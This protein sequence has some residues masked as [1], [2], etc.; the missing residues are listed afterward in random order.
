MSSA[1]TQSLRAIALV[2]SLKK[3]PAPSSSELLAG[4]LLDELRSAGVEGE[5]VRCVD[6]TLL[7]GVEAD[8]G[9]GDEWPGLLDK[10]KAADIVIVSTPTWV[11]HMSSV[12]QRVLER[13]DAELS[14]TDDDG[15]PRMVG[16]VALAAVVGNE[17]GAHKIV[18]DLFQ[19]LNDIGFSIAAQGCTYW[20]GEAMQGTD[21]TDLDDVPDAVASATGNAVRNAVHLASVLRENTYPAYE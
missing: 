4:Q 18:A 17:D 19:A 12:A 14:D 5:K 3:S 21:Y 7:P 15:R 2:C 20:N 16:K 9:P 10:I 8:M 13:L 11:G 1:A 6:L